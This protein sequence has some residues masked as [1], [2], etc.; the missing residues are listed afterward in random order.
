MVSTETVCLLS[1]PIDGIVMPKVQPKSPAPTCRHPLT[2]ANVAE[3][4]WAGWEEVCRLM[5]AIARSAIVASV[6]IGRHRGQGRV[7]PMAGA[8]ACH[9][10][11]EADFAIVLILSE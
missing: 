4:T 5:S 11:P 6:H 7:R 10:D 1:G 9:V 3:A 8:S 2:S